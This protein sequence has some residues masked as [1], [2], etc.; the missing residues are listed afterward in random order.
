MR[1]CTQSSTGSVKLPIKIMV[2][3]KG[4]SVRNIVDTQPEDVNQDQNLF[5]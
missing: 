1:S 5:I 4:Q 3:L 2:Y